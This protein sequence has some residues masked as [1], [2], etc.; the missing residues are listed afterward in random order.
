[1]KKSWNE[2]NSGRKERLKRRNGGHT[3]NKKHPVTAEKIKK[4][5]LYTLTELT[6]RAFNGFIKNT[7]FL[8]FHSFS[9]NLLIPWAGRPQQVSFF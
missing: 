4:N 1:M 9:T 3:G 5:V 2:V 8:S 6:G 7:V